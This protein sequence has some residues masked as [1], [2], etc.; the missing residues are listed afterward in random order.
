MKIGAMN[1]PQRNLVSEIDW[2]GRNGFDFI[3][4]T[5]EEPGAAP[6][7]TDWK[8]V[9][10]AITDS[11]LAV[12]CHAPP[13]LPIENPSPLVRKAAMDEL[14]RCIDVA[15]TVGAPL[16]TTHFMGWPRHL[17]EKDGYEY[18]RQ[19]YTILV[20]HGTEREVAVAMENMPHNKHQLKH[21][22]EVF[23]RVPNLK[24]LLDVG[25]VNV[26]TARS[27][28]RDYL[29][30]LVDRLAHV[31]LSDNDGERDLH[32]SPGAPMSG[33]IN[34]L[35]ELRDLRSFRYDGTITLE[36]FGDR[37]WLLASAQLVRETWERA[38]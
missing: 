18:Y 24:L 14:R 9:R 38:A 20:K 17:S 33:G 2:I 23:Q 28:T 21:F 6:E 1:D 13:Y 32:L 25:H 10:Q 29:F 15:Q 35:Q 37:R 34:L 19:L 4:L 36:V 31:H 27:L 11:G 22:R 26:Q 5:I 7:S 30:A 12:V 8:L 3:D 16:C